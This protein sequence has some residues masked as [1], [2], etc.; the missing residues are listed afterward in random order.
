MLR[1]VRLA[2]SSV[3]RLSGSTSSAVATIDRIG[4]IPDP[5]AIAA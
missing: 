3:A 2:Y 1:A 5:A 4:V